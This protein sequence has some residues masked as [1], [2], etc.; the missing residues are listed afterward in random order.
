MDYAGREATEFDANVSGG[1]SFG[2][3]VRV[4][5]RARDGRRKTSRK[6]AGKR[7]FRCWHRLEP[8]ACSFHLLTNDELD[9]NTDLPNWSKLIPLP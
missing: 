8:C 5:V 9:A 2:C 3:A 6:P 4:T 7:K 1:A